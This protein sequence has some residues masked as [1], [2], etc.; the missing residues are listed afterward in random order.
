MSWSKAEVSSL[1]AAGKFPGIS[2]CQ[3]IN[4]MPQEAIALGV[5]DRSLNTPVTEKTVFEAAS[6]TKPMFAMLV[7]KLV[8]E[9][10]IDL[11]QPFGKMQDIQDIPEYHALH[12]YNEREQL[13][14][15]IIL[16]HYSGLPNA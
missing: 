8:K 10:V 7:L 14:A 6:L 13:T 5:A 11:D 4:G 12:Q 2:F 9:G 16:T 15:R 1:L 3:V